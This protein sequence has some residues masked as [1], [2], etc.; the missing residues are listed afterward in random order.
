MGPWGE[1]SETARGVRASLTC[2]ISRCT[3]CPDPEYRTSRARPGRTRYHIRRYQDDGGGT[4]ESRAGDS[5]PATRS[6]KI[7]TEMETAEIS[8][9]IPEKSCTRYK[10]YLE[11]TV[12]MSTPSHWVP[13]G[14]TPLPALLPFLRKQRV[15]A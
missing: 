8:Q 11:V 2:F 5:T 7:A 12:S 4:I 9:R 3:C 13:S 10:Q 15:R 6:G 14:P 1:V